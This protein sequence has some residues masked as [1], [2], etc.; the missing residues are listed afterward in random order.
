MASLLKVARAAG[1]LKVAAPV[2]QVSGARQLCVSAAVRSG[3]GTPVPEHQV[4]TEPVPEE[5]ELV[6]NAGDGHPEPCTDKLAHN[7]VTPRAAVA[8]LAGAM[9]FLAAVWGAAEYVDKPSTQPFADRVYPFD[10][11]KLELGK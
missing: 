6:W 8:T 5:N 11:L 4:P 10:N 3:M 2:M 1:V 7:I 9:G